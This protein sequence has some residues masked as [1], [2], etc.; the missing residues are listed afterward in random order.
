MGRWWSGR[1]QGAK[2]GCPAM[3][4]TSPRIGPVAAALARLGGTRRDTT[5]TIAWHTLPLLS[6][7]HEEW[8]DGCVPFMDGWIIFSLLF[9][10]PPSSPG[11]FS[12]PTH[13]RATPP[14]IPPQAGR[15][16]RQPG[17]QAARPGRSGS[18]AGRQPGRQARQ[19]WPDA[20]R[21]NQ[22]GIARIRRPRWFP[23]VFVVFFFCLFPPPLLLFSL[24]C[25]PRALTGLHSKH[26]HRCCH[27]CC[28][29]Y[30]SPSSP[31]SLSV[32]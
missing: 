30:P 5:I 18:Q 17:R 29:Q 4:K 32:M 6:A 12:S 31:S 23:L 8:I 21:R 20:A 1:E 26:C 19:N 27:R 15:P 14:P 25:S 11:C 3:T 10:S 24:L 13:K 7:E 9:A 16:G 2:A 22:G 28:H